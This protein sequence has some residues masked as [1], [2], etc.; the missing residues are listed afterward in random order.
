MHLAFYPRWYSS[1]IRLYS[2]IEI[3]YTAQLEW[4]NCVMLFNFALAVSAYLSLQKVLNYGKA[5][6]ELCNGEILSPWY[7]TPWI[8]E[9]ALTKLASWSEECLERFQLLFKVR[10]Q[11]D[12][13]Q[14]LLGYQVVA[15]VQILDLAMGKCRS[16]HF[17]GGPFGSLWLPLAW[18]L[19]PWALITT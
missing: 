13:L 11:I 18:R 3:S 6:I 10:Y 7:F 1:D 17:F 19:A 15:L 9:D 12:P 8:Y 2:R 14:C 4:M 5:F 16:A